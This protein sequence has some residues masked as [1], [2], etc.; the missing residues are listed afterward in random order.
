MPIA[1]TADGA[2][3]KQL[4]VFPGAW[5]VLIIPNQRNI[6]ARPTLHV[7]VRPRASE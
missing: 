2:W 3:V 5:G 6:I 4:G 1:D 7:F